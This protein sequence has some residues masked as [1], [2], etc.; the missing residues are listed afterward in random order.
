MSKVIPSFD[1]RGLLIDGVY[2]P[3]LQE[4]I[5]RFVSVVNM[6]VRTTL[7]EKY[8]EFCK[9]C[10]STDALICHYID[11]SYVTKKEEP[12]DIDLLVIF[13]GIKI[14][15]GPDELYKEYSEIEDRLKMKEEFSCHVYCALEYPEDYGP[16]A[17]YHNAVK[18]DVV[19]WWKTNFLDS[20]RKTQDPIPKGVV[21]LS[22]DEIKKIWSI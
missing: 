13:D 10:L 12:N 3:L 22:E 21:V 17:V 7:F 16:I 11:G 14:D 9:K 6:E 15:E 1:G 4:F 19:G 20:E 8:I 5:D 18:A 2:Y